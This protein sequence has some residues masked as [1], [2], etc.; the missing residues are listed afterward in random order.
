MLN[1]SFWEKS[2]NPT[3]FLLNG[4]LNH[5]NLVT[6]DGTDFKGNVLTFNEHGIYNLVFAFDRNNE[7]QF[8]INLKSN[9]H[10]KLRTYF[11]NS[12]DTLKINL[13]YNLEP[14][15]YL[16]ILSSNENSKYFTLINQV[17]L[18]NS[19]N[20]YQYFHYNFSIL[21]NNFISLDQNS[22]VRIIGGNYLVNN[23]NIKQSWR[24]VHN[25][26]NSESNLLVKNI[27]NHQANAELFALVKIPH[28]IKNAITDVKNRNLLLSSEAKVTTKPQLEIN[29]ED[30]LATH[31]ASIGNISPETIFYLQS[32]GLAVKDAVMMLTKAF[33]E[34]V[35]ELFP[36]FS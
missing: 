1:T 35:Y 24:I 10:L 16:E 2:Q 8:F 26:N 25:A 13:I 20:F 5:R 7:Y 19:S 14:K 22:K 11:F 33:L 18:T 31:G 32:R 6:P 29:S 4:K 12:A 34:E 17:T 15:A 30:V 23:T 3:L 36:K 27:L 28:H 21:E 9:L